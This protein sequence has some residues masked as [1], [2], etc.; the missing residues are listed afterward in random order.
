MAR[1]PMGHGA[2]K[3]QKAKDFKGTIKRLFAYLKPYYFKFLLIMIFATGSTIFMIFGPKILAKA[4]DKLS[5]GIMAKVTNTGGI[6][7]D[8]IFSVLIFL[9]CIY[10]L[11]TLLNYIQGFMQK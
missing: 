10:L 6:D 3:F 8:A 1:G 2:N 4:T 7:F 11:S 5:E 9:T